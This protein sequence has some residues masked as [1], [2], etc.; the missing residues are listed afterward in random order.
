MH[1]NMSNCCLDAQL[2]FDGMQPLL[3]SIHLCCLFLK[4]DIMRTDDLEKDLEEQLKENHRLD[5][6]SK[7]ILRR[8]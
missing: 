3:S 8:Q 6:Y 4:N 1:N 5:I 2:R 7:N